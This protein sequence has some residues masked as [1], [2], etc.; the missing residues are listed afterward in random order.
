MMLVSGVQ[1]SDS[2][3]HIH[4]SILFQILYPFRLLQNIERSSLC[5]KNSRFLLVIYFILFI[6]IFIIFLLFIFGCV[7]SSLLCAG[8]L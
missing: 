6:L 8:F 5:Y 4:V 1:Q 3:I 7:G 2:V